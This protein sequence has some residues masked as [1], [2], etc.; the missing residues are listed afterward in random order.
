[1]IMNMKSRSEHFKLSQYHM[2]H[3]AQENIINYVYLT[4][5]G[6][7][8][9]KRSRKTIKQEYPELWKRHNSSY[10]SVYMY[11]VFCLHL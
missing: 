7:E 10:T 1:M 2:I 9:E 4:K 11:V 8:G 5:S 3:I 6:E